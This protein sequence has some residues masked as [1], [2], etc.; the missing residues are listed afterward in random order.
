MKHGE[1]VTK[2]GSE[3]NPVRKAFWA[4]FPTMESFHA[5]QNQD[6][7]I[8]KSAIEA[9]TLYA[10]KHAGIG[11]PTQDAFVTFLKNN[12]RTTADE[13]L[14]QGLT[15]GNILD[16]LRGNASV[17]T[18]IDELES[19]A[20]ALSMPSVSPS[21]ITRLKKNFSPNTPKKRSL[22]RLLAFVLAQKRPELNWHYELLIQ[23]YAKPTD[24]NLK[25]DTTAGVTAT[26]HLHGQG[27]TIIPADVIWLKNEL[28]ACL[29]DLH[30][31]GRIRKKFIET[32]GATSF[33]LQSPK[34]LGPTHEPGLYNRSLRNILA[35]AHQMSCRWLLC[36][37]SNP[38][39]R[40]IIMIAAGPFL[41]VH[42]RFP[43]IPIN[44]PGD[45]GI[46]LTEYA[47]LYAA[48]AGVRAGFSPLASDASEAYRRPE[49]LWVISDFW[50]NHDYDYIPH[51][52]KANM[53][54]VCRTE[55]SFEI[56]QRALH[57]LEENNPTP[58]GAT[59]A[60]HRFPKSS[61]LLL[62][63]IK[64]LCA[65]R[66]PMEADAVISHLLLN[67]PKNVPGRFMRMLIFCNLADMKE[68]PSAAQLAFERG[69]T[70]GRHIVQNLSANSEVWWAQG[71]LYF[72][73]AARIIRNIKTQ[74]SR[75]KAGSI[76]KEKLL[77]HLK[78]AE[79]CLRR[80]LAVSSTGHCVNC[81]FWLHYVLALTCFFSD[82]NHTRNQ[83][84]K[85][86]FHDEHNVF[87]QTGLR[88]HRVLGW[89][90]ENEST[91]GKH[92][93]ATFQNL[94]GTAGMMFSRFENVMLGRSYIPY[95]KYQFALI[96]WDFSPQLTPA[97]CRLILALLERARKDAEK[98]IY[99]NICVYRTLAGY[100]PPGQFIEQVDQ[101]TALIRRYVREEDL[102]T[103]GIFPDTD[104]F[105]KMSKTKLMLLEI[106]RRPMTAD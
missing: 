70:E 67:D 55:P 45:S 74:R 79:A 31:A 27:D 9:M 86:V 92:D 5:F 68:D 71:M 76:A 53:L 32:I 23:L 43:P 15:F 18:F 34:N 106:N 82:D 10:Y 60:M 48:A 66:M 33:Q 7:E 20:R 72:G 26:F 39:K 46:Y 63:I 24:Q 57:F 98:L 38:R 83:S 97:V 49:K 87:R 37:H 47:Y 17:N 96:L 78:N 58:F 103:S 89:V 62:E 12:S 100:T 102:Q 50:A 94:F 16:T 80:G 54:P 14:P 61:I 29:N 19:T 25:L 90:P 4:A 64:V 95:M 30:M 1:M 101:T 77:D 11:E 56:F 91:E 85:S 13:T 35:V 3:T 6:G 84:K 8:A 88:L 69:I 93:D 44:L 40:L 22:M 105:R 28:T 51:L 99:E 65:R 2:S 21:M 75:T 81:L 59:S 36:P 73:Q 104:S 41:S 42:M 52:L